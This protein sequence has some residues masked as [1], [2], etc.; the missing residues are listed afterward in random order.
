MTERA[1]EITD[2]DVYITRAFDAPRDVV[3]KF[4]TEP[5]LIATWFGPQLFRVPVESVAVDP[6]VGGEY[7]LTMV[8]VDTGEPAPMEGRIT[9]IE[10]PEYLEIVIGTY[11]G[12]DDL[13]EVV[14]RLTFHDHGAKT[15]VTLHQGPFS[16]EHRRMTETGWGE[17]FV[18]LDA[19]LP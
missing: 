1:P 9:A 5:E 4:F 6:R 17:S 2:R 12:E 7:R 13:D 19:L 3:W 18:K 10:P 16:P 14:L 15:R 11:A 8:G